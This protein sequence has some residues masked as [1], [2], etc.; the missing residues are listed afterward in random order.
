LSVID[1]VLIQTYAIC[2]CGVFGIVFTAQVLGFVSTYTPV[3]TITSTLI[4]TVVAW[5]A[6]QRYTLVLPKHPNET[7][8]WQLAMLVVLVIFFGVVFGIRLFT[9][10]YSSVGEFFSSDVL[11]YH[12]PK[13]IELVRTGS[14]WDLSI[15]YG[16]YPNGAESLV[17]FTLLISG[18]ITSLSFTHLLSVILFVLTNTLLI[19][20]YT[21]FSGIMSFTIATVIL[22]IPMVY[23]LVMLVGKNDLLLSTMVLGGILHAPIHP[24]RTPMSW[25]VFGLAYCTLIAVSTKASGV[26]VLG[27]VWLWVLWLWFS[28]YRKQ[29]ARTFLTPSVFVISVLLMLPSTFWLVRNIVM[30]GRVVSPEVSSFSAT[31]LFANWNNPLVYNSGSESLTL[32]L[33]IGITVGVLVLL[34]WRKH[35]TISIVLLV[36][37]MWIGFITSPL[38]AFHTPQ[39]TVLHIEWRYALHLWIYLIILGIVSASELIEVAYRWMIQ[40]RV[41]AW[42]CIIAVVGITGLATIAFG[43]DTL[44]QQYERRLYSYQSSQRPLSQAYEYV[45]ENITNA[46]I[47]YEGAEHLWLYGQNFSNR[48][49]EGRKYPLGMP[50]ITPYPVP[51]YAVIY[52]EIGLANEQRWLGTTY[53]WEVVW[54]D[55][56]YTV[57]KR[58]Q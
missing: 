11:G 5:W 10:P 49:I 2:L 40:R 22:F 56:S 47:W 8:R 4:T 6:Y 51:D 50:E 57:Y 46:T 15:L 26:I 36:G 33:A 13:A 58:I 19:R 43:T 28:A 9:F 45:Q 32:F 29:Q 42:V 55:E 34:L 52:N 16:D 21:P 41:L 44:F 25:H 23:S 20:R 24:K 48:P 39:S 3:L 30:M 1:R 27:G 37:V 54:Q 53:N 38:S 31:S 18:Q 7:T 12:L 17:S 35:L 14:I